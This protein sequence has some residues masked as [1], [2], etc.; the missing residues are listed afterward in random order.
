MDMGKQGHRCDR[1]KGHS[2]RGS[3]TPGMD[4]QKLSS[5]GESDMSRRRGTDLDPLVSGEML[6][7][8]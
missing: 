4:Q 3:N 2:V 6:G 5:K 7:S 1:V 8:Q